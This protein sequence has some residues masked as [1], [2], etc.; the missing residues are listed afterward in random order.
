MVVDVEIPEPERTSPVTERILRHLGQPKWLWIVLWALV[1]L[2]SPL[3][4]A[5]AIRLT[6]QPLEPAAALDLLATQAV[7]AY[8]CFVLLLGSGMLSRQA[9]LV[10]DDVA[11][12]VP[13]N[14]PL[15]LFAGISSV[16][17]PAALTVV[18]ATIITA[19]GYVRQ[20]LAL[21]TFP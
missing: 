13:D 1:P 5:D 15:R 17:G 6:G 16:R 3:V 21:D 7:L 20:P 9:A 2:V 19:G 8:A 18:V 12:L 14:R 4:F 11:R 10:L